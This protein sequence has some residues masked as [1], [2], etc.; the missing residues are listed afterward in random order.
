MIQSLGFEDSQVRKSTRQAIMAMLKKTNHAFLFVDS[1]CRVGLEH[2]LKLVVA[3]SMKMIC[4]VFEFDINLLH[5]KANV[6]IVKLCLEKLIIFT[7]SPISI[8]QEYSKASL[9][10]IFYI[11]V[12]RLEEVILRLDSHFREE[13]EQIWSK[14][15]IG[16]VDRQSVTP[17]VIRF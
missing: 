14:E 1:L 15:K 10:K 13:L 2:E 7:K 16:P 8:L 5:K 17:Q 12:D 6:P 3:K 4:R 11:G 9:I